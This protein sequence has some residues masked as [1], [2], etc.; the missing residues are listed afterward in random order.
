M[1]WLR[2]I[3]QTYF[4]CRSN[5]CMNGFLLIHRGAWYIHRVKALSVLH[6]AQSKHS[7]SIIE[8]FLSS[9][10]DQ[11]FWLR[12]LLP[13][14]AVMIYELQ[15]SDI[16]IDCGGRRIQFVMTPRESNII[17]NSNLDA[18]CFNSIRV[19]VKRISVRQWL[20]VSFN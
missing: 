20:I 8:T 12:L 11:I 15:V 1:Y 18:S 7:F 19:L 14:V 10:L 5:E 16:V 9:D 6:T 4:T 13:N 17:V 2:G 3:T